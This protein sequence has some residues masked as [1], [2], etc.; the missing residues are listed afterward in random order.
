MRGLVA[1]GVYVPRF[2][3]SA[4]DLE[5]A[6]ETSHAAGVERKAV[7]AADEDSLTMAVVAAQRALADAAVDRSA[8]ETVAVATTTPPLEEG[9]F[10]PRLVRALDLPAGVAT[11]TTTHHT[12]A[13][14]EA[15][16]RAL[17][18]DGPAVVIAADCPEGEPADADHP[19]GAAGAAFVIDDDPIVPIDDVAWHSDETPG[20]RFRERGDRDVDSLGVTTYERDA[21]REAVTTA[22]S[23]LEIDAAEA[24]GAA[25]HQR[26]GGFPYR[27]SSDLSVSSEAVAAGT[28]ADRIGDAGA[29]TVPVGLLSALDGADTDELTVA[30]F[31]GG[32]SAAALTCEG[33]LPVR[34]IDDL[35]STETV[36][37][38]TY[39]RERGYIV[40][41]EV[42]GGGANVSLPNWQQSLDH[43]YR[44]VA[45]ACP[46]CGGVTFPPAGA[47][48]ECHA[49]VQFEEFEAP[50]TGTVR[51]VTVI[52]QGG[53]PPEFADLQQR[54]GAYAVAIVALETEHGSVTLPAQLTDVD[55][56]S[57]SVDDTV[58]AAIR[59]IYT[60]E[61]VPRYGVKFRPTDEGS[62]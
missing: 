58:E 7:P 21:V 8:I 62:D 39:L 29:A 34:G 24:T 11:M 32:G 33:S 48:Q 35:E 25:V 56:Q 41:G 45:G 19:F 3:L 1:A 37:Y 57:V 26:D 6:W 51:A 31:F 53:A 23:S 5:A 10:V 36:D 38:S 17:D 44:L 59:R 50:R 13:G 61:G 42:A 15:L 12:A 14:A 52:E 28:V 2:R 49:R 22:V 27:I 4:D 43:R 47:C 9:D 40:D 54:D 55:P 18:A 46:N 30:A 16:S 20:I 60:Q